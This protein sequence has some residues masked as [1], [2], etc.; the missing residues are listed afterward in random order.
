MNII[1]VKTALTWCAPHKEET[2][3][4]VMRMQ[5]ENF[6]CHHILCFCSLFAKKKTYTHDTHSSHRLI[7]AVDWAYTFFLSEKYRIVNW[8]SGSLESSI[9]RNSNETLTMQLMFGTLDDDRFYH[10]RVSDYFNILFPFN[11]IHTAKLFMHTMNKF[12]HLKCADWLTHT[13]SHIFRI[14]NG[15]LFYLDRPILLRNR[16]NSN[17]EKN[18]DRKT[19][20]FIYIFFSLSFFS[21]KVNENLKM[22]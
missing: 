6:Q 14:L 12:L 20:C 7:N 15:I 9:C 17:C 5:E 10:L 2:G 18:T 3:S 22:H 13:Q 21:N 1:Q 11:D 8:K 16:I 4:S 19:V